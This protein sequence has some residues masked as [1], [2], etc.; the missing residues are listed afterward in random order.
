M[1]RKWTVVL[2][3]LLT[4]VACGASGSGVES[5]PAPFSAASLV[6]ENQDFKDYRIY[7]I[8]DVGLQ[9]KLGTIQGNQVQEYRIPD[10]YAKSGA[11]V[12]FIAVPLASRDQPTTQQIV[13]T[14]GDQ[15]TIRIT[16]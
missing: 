16:P 2:A 12:R 14:P 10:T 1:K 8:N 11:P 4:Q 13:L 6:V 9:Y 15:I 7:I 5:E 3:L